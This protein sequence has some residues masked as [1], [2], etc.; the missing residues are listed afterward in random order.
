MADDAHGRGGRLVTQIAMLNPVPA[1]PE[2]PTKVAAGI[3]PVFAGVLIAAGCLI[4]FRH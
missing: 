3:V 2:A 1:A 4:A